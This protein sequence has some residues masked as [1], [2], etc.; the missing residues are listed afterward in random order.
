MRGGHNQIFD[1]IFLDGLHS[2]D[3]LAAAVLT[4]KVIHRHSLDISKICHSNNGVL[5][6]N[7]ILHGHVKLVKSD[8]CSSVVT[9]FV[10]YHD[11]FFFDDA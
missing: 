10:G 5:V 4:L 8:G 11:D 7:Q 6:R 1:E 3:T 9:V 2:L